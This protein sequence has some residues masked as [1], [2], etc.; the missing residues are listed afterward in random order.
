[1]KKFF[2]WTFGLGLL[3]LVLITC[4]VRSGLKK[5]DRMDCSYG[6]LVRGR[7]RY[8]QMVGTTQKIGLASLRTSSHIV[9]LLACCTLWGCLNSDQRQALA[10][11]RLRDQAESRL[12]FSKLSPE[13][14]I[15]VYLATVSFEPPPLAFQDY[16]AAN[17][18][19]LLPVVRRRLATESGLRLLSFVSV[20]RV[21]SEHY[22]SLSNR[23]DLLS[24]ATVC[25][26][27]N[28]KRRQSLGRRGSAQD[29]TSNQNLTTL[30]T[31]SPVDLWDAAHPDRCVAGLYRIGSG[32]GG[33]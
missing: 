11:M 27:E 4:H 26:T 25:N 33:R 31:M 10:I 28:R 30:R 9:L 17:W 24:G 13:K 29:S 3:V 2:T 16:V 18:K 20:L 12:Q 7:G 21:I 19:V 1:M 22:C 32:A 23:G 8:S 14:Q 15:D 6:G 5:R